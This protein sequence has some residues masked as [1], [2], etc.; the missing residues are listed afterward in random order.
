M[1]TISVEQSLLRK[2][3]EGKGR[4]HDIVDLA[5]RLP[6]LG[7]DI[8][9]CD[10]EKLDIEIFPDR[11]DLLS[12]ETLFHGMMPFLHDY[13][14]KPRLDVNPGTISMT[15]SPDLAKIRICHSWCGGER[16]RCR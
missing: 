14:P 10:E 7:T 11:P 3:V 4:K 13:P 2:L 5:F 1:P 15:V 16:S 12:P 8:D 9:N 6:L